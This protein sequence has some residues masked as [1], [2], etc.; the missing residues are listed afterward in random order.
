MRKMPRPGPAPFADPSK[1]DPRF[2]RWDWRHKVYPDTLAVRVVSDPWPIHQDAERGVK[3]EACRIEVVGVA[4]LHFYATLIDGSRDMIVSDG[5]QFSPAVEQDVL[6]HCAL[7]AAFSGGDRVRSLAYD[8]MVH[9]T[10]RD[11][12][13]C[14]VAGWWSE[15]PPDYK[16]WMQHVAGAMV[17]AV[18][19]EV[20]CQLPVAFSA[21]SGRFDAAP[22]YPKL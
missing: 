11:T 17:N 5:V 20:G 14:I 13:R 2:V 8:D 4:H 18:T 19:W 9:K 10:L 6:D 12:V 22:I 7:V 3:V 21:A 1:T 15:I 16:T